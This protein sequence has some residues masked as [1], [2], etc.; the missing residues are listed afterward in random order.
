MFAMEHFPTEDFLVMHKMDVTNIRLDQTIEQ[1]LEFLLQ[2]LKILSL[3]PF[4]QFLIYV[5]SLTALGV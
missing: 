2:P 4:W 1:L 5:G 3:Q